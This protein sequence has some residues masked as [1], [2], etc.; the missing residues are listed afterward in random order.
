V[1]AENVEVVRSFYPGPDV[2]VKALLSDDEAAGRWID[3]VTP[4]VDP[5]FQGTIRLPGLA[6]VS[7]LGL[8]GLRDVWQRWLTRWASFRLEFE[9]VI[10]SGER[11]VAIDRGYGRREP[12]APEEML[13]RTVVWT[14]RDG[15]IASVDFN[16]PHAEALAAIG[17]TK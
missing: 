1:S 10:D 7:F 12:D 6:P 16:V 11:V 5:S 13:R 14:V 15:R 4:L 8:D 3:A 17:L 2:D 9:D